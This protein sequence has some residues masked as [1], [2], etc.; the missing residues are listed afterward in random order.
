MGEVLN[1]TWSFFCKVPKIA[2]GRSQTQYTK[3]KSV[4]SAETTSMLGSPLFQNGNA[5]KDT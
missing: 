5:N 1:L 3:T 2:E 4:Y